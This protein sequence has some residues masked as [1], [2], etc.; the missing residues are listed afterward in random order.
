MKVNIFDVGNIGSWEEL[1]RYASVNFKAISQTLN[2]NVNFTDN[3]NCKFID[4]T[5]RGANIV[6]SIPHG[7]GRVPIMW[8]SGNVTANA[9]VFEGD[10]AD[11][12]NLYLEASA[13]CSARIMVF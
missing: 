10:S 4:V 8:T 3:I 7:L 2:G 13:A 5:F 1:K 6:S 9:V 12:T 11:A